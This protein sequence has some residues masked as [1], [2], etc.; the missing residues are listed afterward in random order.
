MDQKW[1][2]TQLKGRLENQEEEEEEE[3]EKRGL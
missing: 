3:E 2:K 1:R